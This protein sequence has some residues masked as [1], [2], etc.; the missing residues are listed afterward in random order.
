MGRALGSLTNR[1]FLASA[2]L[3][4]TS[5]GAAMY[6]VGVRLTAEAEA[7]LQRDLREAASLVDEQRSSLFDTFTL[8]ARLIA[9]LP[10][11]KAA[12]DTR[13]APTVAPI[14]AGYRHQA[15]ADLFVV[16]DRDGQV[17]A[18]AGGPAAL[19]AGIERTPGVQRALAGDTALA[20][21]PHPRGVLQMVSVPVLL[22]HEQLGTLT[23]GYVLDDDRAAQFKAVTGADIAF[24]LGGL[25]RSSTLGA[26]RH[27]ELAALVER[28][29]APRVTVGGDEYALLVK[30]LPPPAALAAPGLEVPVALI[31]RSRTERMR[32]LSAIQRTLAGLALVTVAA[33]VLVSYGVARTITRPLAALT[34]HMREVAATGD[35]TPRAPVPR[36]AW[37]DEDARVLATTF[38]TLVTS[39][40]RIQREAAQRE[41]LSSLGR[42]STVV[43]HEIR[44]PL[45]IIKGALRQLTRPGATPEDVREAAADIDEEVARLD[46]VVHEVLDFARPVAFTRAPTDVNALCASAAEA[47]AA[48]DAGPEVALELHPG[49]APIA[50]DGERVRT[51]L[52]NLL[53]NARQAVEAAGHTAARGAAVVLATAPAGGGRVSIVVRDHGTGIAPDDLPRIFD[54]Y[55]TTRRTGTGLGL[56]IARNIIEGLGGTLAVASQPGAGTEIRIELGDEPGLRLQDVPAS[57]ASP[58]PAGAGDL[59]AHPA[60]ASGAPAGLDAR[61]S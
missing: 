4:S 41:R 35:L 45:M 7:E 3:A 58:S 30:P 55:F 47:V 34:E 10:T 51:A 37:S 48:A 1:I 22:G 52:V 13:D 49:L 54:P 23:V 53:T 27:G 14:A 33:A 46:R 24:A 25:I 18:A 19:L 21:W 2:L 43:A 12:I 17:L 11:F 32:A 29:S 36:S 16:T 60:A 40:A 42:M 56:P 50:T 44:N 57:D 20:F 39:L 61:R 6:F 5:I 15:G 59:A 8:T 26:E 38:D 9:D 28:P 31:L